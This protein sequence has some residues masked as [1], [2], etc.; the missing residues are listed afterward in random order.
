MKLS[1]IAACIF[2]FACA[3]TSA[4]CA[5]D[6]CAQRCVAPRGAVSRSSVCAHSLLFAAAPPAAR[7]GCAWRRCAVVLEQIEHAH[8]PSHAVWLR[9]RKASG[10]ALVAVQF[11]GQTRP[12]MGGVWSRASMYAIVCGCVRFPQPMF[13]STWACGTFAQS[14]KCRCHPLQ[15]RRPPLQRRCPS[16]QRRRPPL[17]SSVATCCNAS[18]KCSV[19]HGMFG[20]SRVSQHCYTMQCRPQDTVPGGMPCPSSAR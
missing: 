15:H 5:V 1:A 9:A 8:V 20:P 7:Y 2:T 18:Q 16:L 12:K 17:L 6:T 13:A 14:N 4:A 19:Q 11:R 3:C 10:R